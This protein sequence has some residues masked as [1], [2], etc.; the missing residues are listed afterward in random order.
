MPS[1]RC[2]CHDKQEERQREAETEA[3]LLSPRF[4]KT[5]GDKPMS[6]LS[7]GLALG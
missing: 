6:G 5:C 2:D 3:G 7:Q 1:T 4:Q